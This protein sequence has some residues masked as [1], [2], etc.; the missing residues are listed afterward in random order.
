[1]A[2]R[3]RGAVKSNSLT[4]LVHFLF[5][6]VFTYFSETERDRAQ[7]VEGQRERETQNPKQVS[8][9]ST[10]PDTELELTN[11]EITS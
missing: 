1:M 7:V 3:E 5:F 9:V 11:R 6:L 2:E 4:P 8:A 10:G